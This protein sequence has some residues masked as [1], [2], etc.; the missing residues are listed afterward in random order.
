[1]ER[2][3]R[4]IWIMLCLLLLQSVVPAQQP[5][6]GSFVSETP[7]KNAFPLYKPGQTVVLTGDPAEDPGVRRAIGHLQSDLL[8][9][10]DKKP[11]LSFELS[12]G[13]K[14]S[15]VLI[16][17]PG[18]HTH[19]DQLIRRNK[20]DVQQL[21]GKRETFVIRTVDRPFP[22][23]DQALVIAGSDRRG[24]IYGVYELSAQAGVSPWYWWADVPVQKKSALYVLPGT[25]ST[26]EPKVKYRGIFINDEAPA[27][28][29]WTK[30][31]FG[32]FN[33]LFYDK[34]FELILRLKGNM[35]WP[36]MWGNAFYDDDPENAVLA[37]AC[38]V[39]I[40]TSHHEP[41]M[42]A[43][44]EWRRYGSGKWNYAVN[45]STLREF[46]R[47]SIR[48]TGNKESI[49]TLGMRGDG[50]EPMTEGT[51]IS[52]LERIVAD[53]RR[54]LQETTGKKL[55]DI[56][57][58]WALYK[59]V[60]DYYDKGMRVPDEVTLLLCD[61]NWGN[62]R[63]L[64]KPGAA[65]RA[66][67]YG[68]Y[69]HF[70]YVGGPRNYK[71]LN[72]NPLPRIHEQMN[73]AYQYGAR[74][75][76]IVNVG[77]I[78][79]M[80]VPVSFFLDMAWNPELTSYDRIE[81]WLEQWARRQ[82]GPAPAQSIAI[83]LSKYAKYNARR[84]PELLDADTYS[85][86]HQREWERVVAEYTTLLEQA[87][88]VG[89]T[90]PAAHQDAYFQ[91][92]LHPIRACA[93]LYELYDAVARNR[94]Y[95]RQQRSSTNDFAEKARNL[96]QR[97][98]DI[99][100]YYNQTLSGGKWNHLM[101]Q[102]HIGYTYWQQPPENKLPDLASFEAPET[103][104]MGV[105]A[106]GRPD[107][108]TDEN[109]PLV[110]PELSAMQPQS[111]RFIEIFNRGKTPFSWD[112]KSDA[113]YLDIRTKHGKLE[114]QT[115]IEV[116][117]DWEKAPP[118]RTR[119]PVQ[120][121]ASTGQTIPVYVDVYKHDLTKLIDFQGFVE[122]DGYVSMQA[123]HFSR[124]VDS[125]GIHW[126]KLSDL[127][128]TGGAVTFYPV[129]AT[130]SNAGGKKPHLEFDFY[131]SKV[132]AVRVSTWLAPTLAFNESAGLHYGISIDEEPIQ[133]VNLH[134]DHSLQ[135]WERSVANNVSVR[136][137]WHQLHRPGKHTLKFWA[138]DPG[139]VLQHLAIDSGTLPPTYLEPPESPY[140]N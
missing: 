50:D 23:V 120:I 103:A 136:S 56:P 123:E 15:L 132:G 100:R 83:L 57:Q 62:I 12:R 93:N 87:E 1:M 91:L 44:D 97:D 114:K 117:I 115:R 92:V 81:G 40:G 8:M 31:K 37:D 33:H 11:E 7:V 113:G 14:K 82:F 73:L 66:G 84:K 53:Q 129:T 18:H 30:E 43:H 126:Q 86:L 61:D 104:L 76:W 119:I 52:L 75:I 110:L 89:K 17:M 28:S 106:E 29:G 5:D 94:L 107:A 47:S 90:L 80:E 98:A 25:H 116:G 138:I 78:K 9:V 135:A 71:W 77:D 134:A 19:I 49:M 27:L 34:V 46:W 10:T 128:R 109:D 16:G 125:A 137:S 20:L 122:T 42:R 127:G 39:V 72:T 112:I 4:P 131:S 99:S 3:F 13:K 38:G 88:T 64:P 101:D 108:R 139:V 21:A 95:G 70:D 59:E 68:I 65:P 67:G 74:Q 24:V 26:G 55:T 32:G 45:D 63:K 58:V 22:G 118:G 36:A 140:K 102:T 121:S 124:A 130:I 133:A 35:L 111:T 85:I 6:N 2:N 96:F 51:A 60:Q 48:R 105:M 41:M 54:I 79:P 69:Y